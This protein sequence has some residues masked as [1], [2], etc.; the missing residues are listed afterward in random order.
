MPAWKIKPADRLL[1]DV[2]LWSA[3]LANLEPA[4]KRMS[5]YADSF[6]LDVA[7]AHFVPDLLFFPDLIS[8]LRPH[9][10]RPFHVHLMVD[11]PSNVVERFVSAGADLITVH[12]EVGE[13]EVRNAVSQIHA[14]GCAAGVAVRLETPIAAVEPYLDALSAVVLLGT[15]PGVKGKELA[16][17]ACMRIREL[18]ALLELHAL[19]SEMLIIADGGIRTHSVPGLREAGADVIVPGSLVFQAEDLAGTFAWIHS[20]GARA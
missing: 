19:R 15:D 8:A 4:L 7:D 11:E 5:P 12:C 10:E 16:Q 1:A 3:D 13:P 18:G 9:T 2:S 14:L 6:H 20:V 17:N